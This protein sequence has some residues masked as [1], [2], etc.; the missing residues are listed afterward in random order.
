VCHRPRRKDAGSD[1]VA[2]VQGAGQHVDQDHG[3]QHETFGGSGQIDDVFLG[4]FVAFFILVMSHQRIGA[5]A[6][7]LVEEV[8]GQQI[9]GKGYADGAEQRQGKAGVETGLGMFMQ[10]AHI[11]GRIEHCQDP[12]KEATRAKIIEMC[13]HPEG[14]WTAQAGCETGCR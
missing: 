10:A 8:H 6:D 5:D 11:S 14:G 2:E 3:R 4:T 12:E 9:V 13:I 1:V 7:D